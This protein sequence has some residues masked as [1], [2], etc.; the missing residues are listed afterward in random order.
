[1]GK[2]DFWALFGVAFVFTLL[3]LRLRYKIAPKMD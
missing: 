1:M 3:T 2:I